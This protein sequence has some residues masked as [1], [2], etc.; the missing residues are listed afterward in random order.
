[1]LKLDRRQRA[2]FYF[3]MPAFVMF[4]LF[5]AY[6]FASTLYISLT[7]WNGVSPANFVGLDNYRQ[8]WS[9]ETMWLALTNNLIWVGLGTAIPVLI[10]LI[11]AVLLW[12]GAHGSL[13]FRTIYFLP[14]IVSP[15]VIAIIWGW[16]YNP[17]FGALNSVLEAVGLGDWARGW[18]GEAETALYAVL[19]AAIWSYIGFCVVVLFAGLQKVDGS[20]IDAARIDGASRVNQMRHVILPQIRPVLTTVIVYTVIG[21]FNVFDIVFVMTNGG[22]ANASELIATYT[23]HKSF[24]EGEVGYGAALSVVMTSIALATTLLLMK[25][26]ERED[27]H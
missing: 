27:E 18:L 17:S 10:G 15:V 11:L 9:D 24:A 21:G 14:V 8:M 19:V 7:D 1:M 20:L 2:G 13:A 6:P 26:R 3:V 12:N 4:L 23:Y 16:I 5:F 25:L 22:P